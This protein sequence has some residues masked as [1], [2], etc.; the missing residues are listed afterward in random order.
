M[1]TSGSRE[2][3]RFGDFELDVAAY[4]LRRRGRPVKLGR[5]PMDVLILLVDRRGL[6]VPRSEIVERLWGKDVFVD[7]E[8]GVNTAISKIRQA[9]RDSTD[10]PVFLETVPGKGYRFIANVESVANAEAAS[11]PVPDA[12][13]AASPPPEATGVETKAVSP[14]PKRG[15]AV[16]LSA[17]IALLVVLTIGIVAFTKLK[18]GG[19]TPGVSLAVLPFENL[20]SDSEREYLAAGLTDETSAS[21]AQIDPAHLSVKGRTVAYK[22]TTKTVPEIGKELSVDYLVASSIRTEGGRLRVAVTLIRVRDQ[23]HVWSQLFDREPTSL[24]G[25]Q[26]ELSA[27]IAEQIRLRLSPDRMSGLGRRQTRDAGAYDAYLRGRH[28]AHL[29][30]PDGNA[31]AVELLERA[32]E[33]DPNY[34]LAWSDLA[35]TY[36]GSAMNGDARPAE[37]GPLARAAARHAVRAN[38]ELS[39]AQ[40][41]LGHFLWLIDWDWNAAEA[42]LRLAIDLD[43]SNGVAHRT[44][45]H[46]LSQSGRRTE[47]EAAMRRARELDPLDALTHAL[48][49][50]VAFQNRD[51]TA[52]I[53]H[54]RRAIVLGPSLW[55][56]YVELAQAYEG[57]G[58]YA[59]ALEA[60]ADGARLA[61]GNSK[62]V[63]NQGYA[64][65]KSGHADAAREALRT[66]EA[67]ARDRYVPPYATALVYAGL[68]ERDAVFTSLEKAYAARDVHLIF[69]PVDMRWD[70]YRNEPRFADLLTR[71]GFASAR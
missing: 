32:L 5:Q 12:V 24:L 52:A 1:P 55:V 63:S 68:G 35:F 13:P 4:E 31:R 16:Q 2:T 25:L 51:L 21:L 17:G 39:E 14:G 54:A 61:G 37:V 15:W 66:L 56:G 30:T 38:P 3:L 47:A 46:M 50:Q 59:L 19:L 29:R 36:S 18:G 57:A 9:L 7:V 23:E 67:A 64:L 34:A 22:G 33:I 48:S 20:G 10:A 58:E 62:V 40:L 6:L 53:D 45:G 26:Q 28:Q 70:P 42:A 44:L 71:C 60:L 27:A 49:A 65:A 41:A 43:P 8:T 69:L 11:V